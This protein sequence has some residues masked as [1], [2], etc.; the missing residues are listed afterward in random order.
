M[1]ALTRTE[2]FLTRDEHAYTTSAAETTGAP[3]TLAEGS[4]NIFG[5]LC[6]ICGWCNICYT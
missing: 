3:V 1:P 6:Y 5:T 4:V 2:L